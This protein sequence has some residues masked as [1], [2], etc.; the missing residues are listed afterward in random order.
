MK[1]TY[2][3]EVTGETWGVEVSF[4]LTKGRPGRMYLRN[5]DPGYPP[6]PAEVEDVTFQ[7]TF[8]SR[9]DEGGNLIEEIM[10]VPKARQK[11]MNDTFDKIYESDDEMKQ[12]IDELAFE[13]AAEAAEDNLF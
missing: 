2:E 10:D 7:V 11:E 9:H 4:H 8:Y 6:E 12:R 13:H 1:Y 5:G 3:N